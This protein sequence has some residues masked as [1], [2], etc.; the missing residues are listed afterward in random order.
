MD[1]QGIEFDAHC[2]ENIEEYA[3]RA[4]LEKIGAIHQVVHKFAEEYRGMIA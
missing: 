1:L 3:K 4:I 2:G